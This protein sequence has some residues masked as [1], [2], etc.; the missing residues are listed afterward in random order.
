MFDFSESAL[1]R[2]A[3]QFQAETKIEAALAL[4]KLNTEFY[5]NSGMSYFQLVELYS[6]KGNKAAAIEHYKKSLEL[7]PQNGTAKKKLEELTNL[8]RRS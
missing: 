2:L 8:L 1:I 6:A 4:L 5:P 7:N 3:Q